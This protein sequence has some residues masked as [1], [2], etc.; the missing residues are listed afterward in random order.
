MWECCPIWSSDGGYIIFTPNG[1]GVND[2][3]K[4]T[5]GGMGE[6]ELLL[7]SGGFNF[8]TAICLETAGS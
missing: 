2:L 5:V 1:Q 4:K 3:Y 7:K 8:P 6:E